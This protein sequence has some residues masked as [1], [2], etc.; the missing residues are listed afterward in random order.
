M[1]RFGR[2]VGV[3]CVVLYIQCQKWGRW[4]STKS[5]RSLFYGIA[6]QLGLHRIILVTLH[7]TVRSL[8]HYFINFKHT[9]PWFNSWCRSRPYHRTADND[10]RRRPHP[11]KGGVMLTSPAAC[12]QRRRF[13]AAVVLGCALLL[14]TG[15]LLSSVLL[16]LRFPH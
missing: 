10:P 4:G 15:V 7:R 11:M 1:A 16:R 3:S 6:G 12:H 9:S 2:L 8:S 13:D 5:R 14:S